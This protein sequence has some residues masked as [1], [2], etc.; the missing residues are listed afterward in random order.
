MALPSAT[1]AHSTCTSIAPMQRVSAAENPS[2][3]SLCN[4]GQQSLPQLVVY[5]N[6]VRRG[7]D[8][9]PQAPVVCKFWRLGVLW[10]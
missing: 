1:P 8:E 10:A 4:A 5:G 3:Q 9:R 2:R 7:G 6:S